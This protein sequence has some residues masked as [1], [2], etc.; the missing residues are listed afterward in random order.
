MR[1]DSV[2]HPTTIE[3]FDK[4]YHVLMSFVASKAVPG[5][6]RKTMRSKLRKKIRD[7][8]F[9]DLEQAW[10]S[11]HAPPAPEPAPAPAPAK[12]KEEAF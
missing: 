12:G 7:E 4:L 3:D 5:P 9:T 10:E 8:G 6:Q 2:S 11:V 1:I